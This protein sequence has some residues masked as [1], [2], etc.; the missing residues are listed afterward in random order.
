MESPQFI[1]TTDPVSALLDFAVGPSDLRHGKPPSLAVEPRLLTH[2][3]FRMKGHRRNAAYLFSRERLD[4][5]VGTTL[6]ELALPVLA[7]GWCV[8]SC[9]KGMQLS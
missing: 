3:R 8:W 4:L 1:L 6:T 9:L 7:C 5:S 2:V